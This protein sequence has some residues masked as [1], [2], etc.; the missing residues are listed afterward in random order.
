MCVGFANY[1]NSHLT[2]VSSSL[3]Y[4]LVPIA[5]ENPSAPEFGAEYCGG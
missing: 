5:T 4:F 1:K 3:L 2:F